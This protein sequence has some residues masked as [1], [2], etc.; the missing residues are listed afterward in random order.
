VEGV[1]G[2]SSRLVGVSCFVENV[3]IF[4]GGRGGGGGGGGQGMYCGRMAYRWK[5]PVR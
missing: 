1:E 5:E 2:N 3:R 4:Q